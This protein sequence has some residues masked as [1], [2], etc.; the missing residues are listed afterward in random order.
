V[1]GSST[2]RSPRSLKIANDLLE[3]GAVALRPDNPFTWASGLRSPIYCDNRLTLAYPKIRRQICDG[4]S[5]SIE[6]YAGHCDVIAGTATAGIPHAA[7]LAD[8]MNLPLVYVRSGAKGHGKRNQ[9]EGVLNEHST[10]VL[11]EDLI[12]TGMSSIAAARALEQARSSVSL[13]LAIFSYEMDAA[14]KEFRE[15]GFECKALCGY[16]TLIDV[17]ARTGFVDEAGAQSLK[18][19]YLDPEGWSRSYSCKS[20]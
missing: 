19:W 10:V 5:E 11:I 4:F 3:I 14:R 18:D 1:S 2:S 6:R 9:I 7:W 17:A 8:R 12:S 15:T 16:R 20:S 13:V